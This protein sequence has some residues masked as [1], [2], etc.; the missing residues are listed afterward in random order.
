MMKGVAAGGKTSLIKQ[1]LKRGESAREISREA[2]V[3]SG[4]VNRIKS[5]LKNNLPTH[6]YLKKFRSLNPEKRNRER[7]KNYDAGAKYDYSSRIRYSEQEK[8]LVLEFK[9][10][11]R[12]LAKLISRSV[13]AVQAKRGRMKKESELIAEGVFNSAISSSPQNN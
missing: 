3:S 5:C 4:Y 9:G 1:M 12:E 10:T 7:K 8:K 11:D 2:N 6:F 13:K